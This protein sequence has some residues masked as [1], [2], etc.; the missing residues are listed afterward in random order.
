MDENIL[1]MMYSKYDIIN[2]VMVG[3]T[4]EPKDWRTHII[5]IM[6]E[7]KIL[8]FKGVSYS[9][10][11]NR[12]IIIFL[13]GG[14]D[15]I[16]VFDTNTKKLLSKSM[17]KGTKIENFSTNKILMANVKNTS[18]NPIHFTYVITDNFEAVKRE[19][20]NLQE[21]SSDDN[22]YYIKDHRQEG[23]ESYKINRITGEIE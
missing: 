16:D 20:F 18:H 1:N 22:F 15:S 5:D 12:F 3:I 2:Q 10:C 11:D 9:I 23:I 7:D 13:S 6:Y 4:T 14:S 17:P 8:T 21:H 19:F